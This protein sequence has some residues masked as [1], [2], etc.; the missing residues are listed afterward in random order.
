MGTR[1][2]PEAMNPEH[3][4]ETVDKTTP[5]TISISPR[6]TYEMSLEIVTGMTGREQLGINGSR[7]SV[8]PQ[9]QL[10]H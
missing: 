9:L 1:K 3:G 10:F 8:I 7:A 6:G 2:N 5:K 4:D